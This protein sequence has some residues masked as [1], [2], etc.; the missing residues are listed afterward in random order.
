MEHRQGAATRSFYSYNHFFKARNLSD[1]EKAE[2]FYSGP[3]ASL[4]FGAGGLTV[5]A[6]LLMDIRRWENDKLRK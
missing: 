3:G 6:D 2:L 1:S 4:L 5:N